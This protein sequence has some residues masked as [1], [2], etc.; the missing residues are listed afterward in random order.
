MPVLKLIVGIIFIIT[1]ILWVI[2]II[3]GNIAKGFNGDR[4]LVP[5][6]N[7]LFIHLEDNNVGFLATGIFSYMCLYM[8]WA[9]QK[10]NIKFG[11][12]I[13]CCC[14]FHPMKEN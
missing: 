10:G 1:S 14:R 4:P 7:E 6:L 13:P 5:M 2:Q 11:I 12:R 8:L 3:F 9:V